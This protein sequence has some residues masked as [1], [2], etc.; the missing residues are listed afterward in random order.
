MK[1]KITL[2]LMVS[3][4]TFAF[5]G[6][7]GGPSEEVREAMDACASELGLEK[8]ERGSRPSEEDRQKLDSCMSKKGFEKPERPQ[9]RE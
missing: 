7:G 2:L 9:R 4:L 5:G 3:S 8:P 1:A 6:R